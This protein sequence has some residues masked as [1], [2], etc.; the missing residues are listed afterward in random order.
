MNRALRRFHLERWKKRVKGYWRF[1]YHSPTEPPYI[2]TSEEVGVVANTKTFC[3][4][5]CC[6]NRRKYEGRSL[7][8]LKQFDSFKSQLD[9]D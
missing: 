1:K 4:R 7:Q 9:N 3:S 5:Y 8:E 2:P 6:G